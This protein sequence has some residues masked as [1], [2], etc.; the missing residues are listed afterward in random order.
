MSSHFL[1]ASILSADFSNLKEQID[2][3]SQAGIDWVHIDVID[4]HFAPNITMG[5]FIVETVRKITNLLIDVHLMIEKPENHIK[6]FAEAGANF[7]TVHI[8]NNPNIHRTLQEIRALGC[9][10]GIAIN[11]GTPANSIQSIIPNIDLAL[12]MTVNPGFS[13]QK[14]IP[15]MLQKII[16]VRN[17]LGNEK[18]LEV[19][20]GVNAENL[21]SLLQ[22][23]ANAFVA[24]T[25]IFKFSGGISKGV[26]ELKNSI[27]KTEIT[28]QSAISVMK[29]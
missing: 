19:D 1:S 11:P 3:A 24:A 27:L 13:G 22:S 7:L 14:F 4:G 9:R 20:G 25:S 23:G 18:Y 6:S 10:P 28:D 12:V 8:E 26:L 29:L 2:T 15:E 16:E 17:L 5:P 21:P